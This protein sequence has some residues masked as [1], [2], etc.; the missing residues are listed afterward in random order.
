MKV[1]FLNPFPELG[2][3]TNHL[4]RKFLSQIYSAVSLND[5]VY[6]TSYDNKKLYVNHIIGDSIEKEVIGNN[7]SSEKNVL[8]M[9][10]IMKEIRAWFRKNKVDYVYMRSIP[11]TYVYKKTRKIIKE[12]GAIIV[13]EIPSYPGNEIKMSSRKVYFSLVS[14]FVRMFSDK[15]YTDLYAVIGEPVEIY[16]GA[17]AINIENGL[18]V[19]Q[20]PL[21]KSFEDHPGEIHLLIVAVIQYWHG[22]DR[23]I[24]G[25]KN[26][27][28]NGR[29][30][31]IFLHICGTCHD[32][33]LEK[34]LEYA[35]ENGFSDE[36]I[37]H[38]YQSGDSLTAIFEKC[39][40][41]IGSLGLHRSG[42]K[43]DTTLKLPEYTARGIP[44]IY[45]THS[46]NVDKNG[47][48]YL[49]IP[50]DD[51]DVDIDRVVSFFENIDKQSISKQMRLFAKE[52]LQ[53]STQ[54]KKIEEKVKEISAL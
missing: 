46:N 16:N 50:D 9:H 23:L 20:V 4:Y 41:A 18:D 26:Y 47:S 13:V 36:I 17:P 31:K 8:I 40:V 19:K 25:I 53:W 39:D 3:S 42:I 43:V 27:H 54:L 1:I 37:C 5:D 21:K 2:G 45:C 7:K 11:P 24:K 33:S 30:E 15:K 29:P 6:Y 44:F 51:S 35:K 14:A 12:S 34:F 28:D 22:Y 32:G 48:Y 38:G 10:Q 49:R 52:N